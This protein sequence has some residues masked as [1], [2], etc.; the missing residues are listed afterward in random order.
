[1]IDTVGHYYPAGFIISESQHR[2]GKVHVAHGINSQE[3]TLKSTTPC[4]VHY[5]IEFDMLIEMLCSLMIIDAC[6]FRVYII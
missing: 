5:D 1:M 4:I 3:Q 6:I 2:D